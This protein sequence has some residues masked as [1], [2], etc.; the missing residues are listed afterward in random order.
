MSELFSACECIIIRH[1]KENLNKCSLRYVELHEPRGF[2]FY[3]YPNDLALSTLEFPQGAFLLH[4]EGELLRPSIDGPMVVL[5][6][7]WRYAD[8]MY[9][10]LPC[11]QKIPKYRLPPG[12][13]TAYPRRQEDCLDP[14]H[15]LSSLEAIFA[16]SV[17]LGK[18]TTRLLDGYY[19]KDLFLE[20]NKNVIKDYT[21]L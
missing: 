10:A 5:D 9:R 14:E 15:G 2:L 19:W 12:W 16:A 1:R 3:R 6:G 13:R 17:L 21:L 8:R 11:V 7:T 20:K 18:D 4:M